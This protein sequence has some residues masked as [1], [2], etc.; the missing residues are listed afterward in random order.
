MLT[1]L[2]LAN[3]FGFN[4]INGDLEALRRPVKVAKLDRPGVELLGIFH[5]HEKE[6][7]MLIGNK[8]IALI[9][10]SDPE[11]VYHNCLKIFAPECPCIIITQGNDC[12]E[13]VLRA[14][15]ETNAP[16]FSSSQ[17][18]STLS[19]DMYVYLSEALAPK[20]ALHAV[21]MEIYGIGVLLLGESGIGKSEISLD[22][23][24]KGHR[25]IADDRVDI[26]D[27]RGH[28]IGTCP[29]SIA[30]MM[31]VRGIGIINVER[32]FGVNSLADKS[33]IRLVIHLVPFKK[34]EPLERIGM[35][36]DQFEI[37]GETVPL[38]K[39]PVS[40]ARSMSE[41]IET[42]VTNFKLKDYGYDTGYEFQKRLSELHQRA[43][44][45]S[46]MSTSALNALATMKKVSPT[47]KINPDH[48][49]YPHVDS[50]VVTPKKDD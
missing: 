35:K 38:I 44:R 29:E 32:M 24:R 3:H 20:T 39:L 37:L 9:N 23:I 27:V 49:P 31:E 14:A 42:A 18:T 30:G 21:L 50:D 10:D 8:E 15:K 34:D 2:E 25:L 11:F 7:I 33:R 45:Q 1:N 22:L 40:A 12:P 46:L 41:I 48:E 47:D 28:L 6:R 13:P 17:D 43:R 4:I 16:L 5:F 19:S 26:S 36:T